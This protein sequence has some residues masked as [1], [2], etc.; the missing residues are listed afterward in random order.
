MLWWKS[1]IFR[2]CL[3]SSF[4]IEK[5]SLFL[6]KTQVCCSVHYLPRKN[7][8][9]NFAFS[10]TE[11]QRGFRVPMPPHG[12]LYSSPSPQWQYF[13]CG[14]SLSAMLKTDWTRA[15]FTFLASGMPFSLS[16]HLYLFPTLS[17]TLVLVSISPTSTPTLW[18]SPNLFPPSS[19]S[20]SISQSIPPATIFFNVFSPS[21][22][23]LGIVWFSILIGW[24]VVVFSY[25]Q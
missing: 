23:Y 9:W 6:D 5:E 17:V 20:A 12:K 18:L 3:C 11:T 15:S 19:L 25:I 10:L 24:M 4:S 14:I 13:I 22:C 21:H 8:V 2:T 7:L 16:L 1:I